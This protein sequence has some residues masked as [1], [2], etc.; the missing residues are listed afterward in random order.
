[1]LIIISGV[2]KPSRTYPYFIV[3]LEPPIENLHKVI[4][5]NLPNDIA[6]V[7]LKILHFTKQIG[8]ITTNTDIDTRHYRNVAMQIFPPHGEKTIGSSFSIQLIGKV[9]NWV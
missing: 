2:Q 9:N 8:Y 5:K 6:D 4:F 7:I 3:D 1:M